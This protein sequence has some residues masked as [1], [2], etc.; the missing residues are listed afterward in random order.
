MFLRSCKRL[1][2]VSAPVLDSTS[3]NWLVNPRVAVC[4]ALKR[5]TTQSH[6]NKKT[7]PVCGGRGWGISNALRGRRLWH[8]AYSAVASH[9]S[10]KLKFGAKWLNSL[11]HNIS[12]NN[13]KKILSQLVLK[14]MT[15]LQQ[16]AFLCRLLPKGFITLPH[17]SSSVFYLG[18]LSLHPSSSSLSFLNTSFILTRSSS[19]VLLPRLLLFFLFFC[20]AAFFRFFFHLLLLYLNFLKSSQSS[21]NLF[22][23]FI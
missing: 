11:P 3:G 22:L 6:F 14:R 16:V 23:S 17:F 15:Q 7:N 8:S 20:R 9:Y 13:K 5:D 10:S 2:S 19:Q 1:A 18:C 12:G 4:R 21:S